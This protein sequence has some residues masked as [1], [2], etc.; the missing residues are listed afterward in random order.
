MQYKFSNREYFLY[1]NEIYIYSYHIY[2]L[3]YDNIK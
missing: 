3:N 1:I 2:K